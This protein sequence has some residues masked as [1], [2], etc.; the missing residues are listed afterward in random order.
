MLTLPFC[1]WTF[2]PTG[3][4]VLWSCSRGCHVVGKGGE[5]EDEEGEQRKV[6]GNFEFK[7]KEVKKKA[8]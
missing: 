6:A 7:H 2:A 1:V 5:V 4:R 8:G 3:S